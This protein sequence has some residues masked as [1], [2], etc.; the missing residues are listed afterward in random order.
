MSA[1]NK[2]EPLWGDFED[3]C[4]DAAMNLAEIPSCIAPDERKPRQFIEPDERKPRQPTQKKIPAPAYQDEAGN[5]EKQIYYATDEKS[6]YEV[7]LEAQ[8]EW[9]QNKAKDWSTIRTAAKAKG[10]GLLVEPLSPVITTLRRKSPRI[11]LQSSTCNEQAHKK[12]KKLR[13]E[14]PGSRE[15]SKDLGHGADKKRA[16]PHAAERL[17]ARQREAMVLLELLEPSTQKDSFGAFCAEFAE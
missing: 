12:N 13:T 2:E 3:A 14:E 17:L 16:P 7:E 6:A 4:H 1:S 5:E 10:R 8:T 15:R 11:A 9:Y